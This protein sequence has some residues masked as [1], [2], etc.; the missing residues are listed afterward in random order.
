MV[1][2]TK[3]GH[4]L[5]II[6]C[7]GLNVGIELLVAATAFVAFGPAPIGKEFERWI[8][9]DILA[10][11]KIA[12]CNAIDTSNVEVGRVLEMTIVIRNIVECRSQPFAV[13]TVRREKLDEPHAGIGGTGEVAFGQRLDGWIV[14]GKWPGHNDQRCY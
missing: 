8:A 9:V 6:S 7:F 5:A 1:R 3:Q 13:A 12:L 2:S 10:R 14:R 11:T 4:E